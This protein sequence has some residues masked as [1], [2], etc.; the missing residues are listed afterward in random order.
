MKEQQKEGKERLRKGGKRG[1]LWRNKGMSLKSKKA[2]FEETSKKG[3]FERT[4]K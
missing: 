3:A 2:T 1:V 4:S